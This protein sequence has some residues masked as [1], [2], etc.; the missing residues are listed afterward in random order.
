ML[1]SPNIKFNEVA[2][3][4]IGNTSVGQFHVTILGLFVFVQANQTSLL[5]T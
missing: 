5:L 4:A 1:T 3:F 2:D